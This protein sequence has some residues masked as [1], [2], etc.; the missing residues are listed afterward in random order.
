MSNLPAD[1][2]PRTR[3][4]VPFALG[5]TIVS[6]ATGQ[7]KPTRPEKHEIT[8][9]TIDGFTVYLI[10]HKGCG[11]GYDL[12]CF[13][14]SRIARLKTKRAKIEDQIG[15]LEADLAEIDKEIAA[16]EAR[17][18]NSEGDDLPCPASTKP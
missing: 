2:V 8:S 1:D 18:I 6:A 3:D 9:V 16:E 11:G 7:E 5:M 13:Y 10:G 15:D 17:G 12:R 4:G 14:S